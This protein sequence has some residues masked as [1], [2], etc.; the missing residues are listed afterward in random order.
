MPNKLYRFQEEGV[1]FLNHCQGRSLIGDEMGLGKT[2]Q[3]LEW[4]NQSKAYPVLVVCPGSL[5]V[6]WSRESVKWLKKI[7]GI[8]ILWSRE[9]YK[10]TGKILIINYDILINWTSYLKRKK[11]QTII[12]DECQQ[13]KNLKTQ[14][15]QA[16]LKVCHKVPHVIGLSGTP[17]LNRPIEFFNILSLIA[18]HIFPSYLKYGLRYCDPKLEWGKINYKGASNTV[19]LH[20][21]VGKVMIRRLKREVLSELPDKIRTVVP[22]RLDN[23]SDYRRAEQDL[24]K[25]IHR[26]T[27]KDSAEKAAKAEALTR[28]AVLKKL[29]MKGKFAACA[30]WITNFLESDEK[31]IVFAVHHKTID[32]VVNAFPRIT[33]RV[34]SRMS[35]DARQKSVDA[36]QTSS[37]VR[38]IVGGLKSM[39]VGL[40]LT[41]ASN[42]CM[43][44]L[45]WSPGEHDQAESRAHRIGQTNAVNIW[46]LLAEESIEEKISRLIDKKRKVVESVLDGSKPD[47]YALLTNLFKQY[48][49]KNEL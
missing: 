7:P 20:K 34:D 42:V 49:G 41:A 19:E 9:P 13:I 17:I 22:L 3:A 10:V 14:R 15:T 18:P 35:M 29:A 46:Y 48:K 47:E 32:A 5:K 37:N 6:N 28:V 27:G 30:E 44:E 31:L 8:E 45:G 43:L 11:L 2:V 21:R 39:G 1:A 4:L 23:L 33:V 36:F 25:W 26:T 24:I 40:T 38:L 16:V 12:L